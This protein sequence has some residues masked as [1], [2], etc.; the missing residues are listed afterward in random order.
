MI[1]AIPPATQSKYKYI[2]TNI[3]HTLLA[4]KQ[5][6]IF[7]V[8]VTRNTVHS[9]DS[10]HSQLQTVAKIGEI[11]TVKHTACHL[12]FLSTTGTDRPYRG[13]RYN[14]KQA[15]YSD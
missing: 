6:S 1:P 12:A 3:K 4:Y 2:S 14:S 8:S 9:R 11:Y 5:L 15:L 7:S 10:D 13:K